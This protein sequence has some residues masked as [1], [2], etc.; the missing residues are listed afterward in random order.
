MPPAFP[1]HPHAHHPTS[2][3]YSGQ[4]QPSTWG[5]QGASGRMRWGRSMSH[6]LGGAGLEHPCQL[7]FWPFRQYN[8]TNEVFLSITEDAWHPKGLLLKLTGVRG[9]QRS[10]LLR[11]GG[12]FWKKALQVART[13]VTNRTRRGEANQGSWTAS[14][15]CNTIC[16]HRA[17][18]LPDPPPQPRKRGGA[19]PQCS[20]LSHVHGVPSTNKEGLTE[21]NQA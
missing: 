16:Y 15:P 3:G 1:P 14:Q 11:A 19:R 7:F 2:L 10:S 8:G 17:V 18:T 6:G 12:A 9:R 4:S 13:C 5:S 21:R 20:G